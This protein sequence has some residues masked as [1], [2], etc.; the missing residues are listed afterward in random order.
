MGRFENKV[1]LITGS[2]QGVGE[3]VARRFA[4]EGAAGI[5]VCGRNQQRGQAVAAALETGGT[6][7]LFVPVELGDAA[8]CA[9]LLAATDER[10]GRLDVLINAAALT[11]RGSI[12]DTSVDLWDTMMGVNLRAPFLLMQGAIG[13][14]RR[15]G[16]GGSIVNVGSIVSHGGPPN[17]MPYSV[18]KAGLAAMTRNIA[19][20]V[21]WD[22]IR[23]NCINP[24]WMDTPGEDD[25]QRRF[26]GGG[27]DWLEKAEASMPSGQLIK[28]DEIAAAIAFIASDESGVMNGSVVDYDQS[29]IGAGDSPVPAREDTP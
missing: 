12:V 3:A 21:A 28:T 19:Y 6:D 16:N 22:G 7:A 15:E 24:G 14:M 25:T 10:F 18:S 26:E 29:I 17:L 8:S 9:A 5:V 11:L 13:I 20:S 4:A 23:V 1:A 27:D 2:T